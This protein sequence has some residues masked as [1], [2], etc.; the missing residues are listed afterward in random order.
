[1]SQQQFYD[2]SAPSNR[3]D[4]ISMATYRDTVVLV[5]N[6]ASDCGFTPQYQGLEKLQQR[7][8]DQGFTVL[9]FPCNQFGNQESG[10]DEEIRQFCDL[11]FNISFPL[12]AKVEVNG[13]GAH[14]LFQWLKSQKGGLLGDGIKWNFTKF[15]IDRQ[16]RVVKRYAPTVKPEQIRKDIEA[17]L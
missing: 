11:N 13:R 17:L 8:G 4:N 9:A 5:V 2:F 1:M 16:G 3:H 12:F 6:T 10:S 15:L 7:Y 14:P